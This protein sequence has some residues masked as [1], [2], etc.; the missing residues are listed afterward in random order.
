MWVLT[1]K[2]EQNRW[3]WAAGLAAAGI[4]TG[5][6]WLA[7]QELVPLAAAD[8]KPAA[9]GEKPA[10]DA[11]L[12]VVVE[13]D[14]A[15]VLAPA[16]RVLD[17]D[18]TEA[19]VAHFKK[20]LP[21]A[22]L[23]LSQRK[24]FHMVALGDS[25]VEMFGYDD[26]NQNWIKG[27]PARFA[28][29]LARQFFYTGGV[30]IVKPS[31][32]KPEKTQPHR[33]KEITLRNLGRG[34]KLSIHAM[35]PLSTYGL[36]TP[37]DLVLMSFG[38]NDSATGLDLGVY[39]KAFQDLIATV[40]AAGGE[41]VLLGPTTIVADPPEAD[42]A[43]TRPYSDTLR[44]VAEEAGAFYVDLGNL[45]SLV[46]VPEELD[47]PAEVFASVVDQ[48]RQFF[49][50]G[51]VVDW[52]H[53]R[54]ALHE[55]LGRLIF[56]ELVDGPAPVPWEVGKGELAILDAKTLELKVPVKNTTK[57]KAKYVVLPLVTPQWKPSDAKPEMELA[58]GESRELTIRYLLKDGVKVS[59]GMP[60][61]EPMLRL[62]VMVRSGE[63]V[64]IM[65]VRATLKPAVL[66]WKI[67]TQFNVEKE[68]HP[69][70]LLVNTSGAPLSG[71]WEATWMG[72][73]L[74]GDYRLDAGAQQELPLVF[75]LPGD[76][77]GQP[78][79]QSSDLTVVLTSGAQVL[80][81]TRRVDLT[82]N[83]GLKQPVSMMTSADKQSPM[84]PELGGRERSITLKAD[85]DKDTLFLTFDLR[86]ID[87]KDDPATGQS[88]VATLN[89]DAR[90]YGK[91]LNR[92]VT[93]PLR[94]NGPA[95]DG[96]ATVGAIP[97]WAFGTGYA[98]S[99]DEKHVK[100][101]VSSGSEGAR[102][103]TISL[104]RSYLY[105]HEWALGN[106]NSQI[107]INATF[108]FWQAPV[109]G[110]SAG[111]YLP[112]AQHSLLFNRH[113]DDAEGNAALELTTEPTQ[114]WT[115]TIQ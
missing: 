84:P 61:H 105:L 20:M 51:N 39:A 85:A 77:K 87:L 54:P 112:D 109:P 48:Y 5:A 41:V 1:P 49:D 46:K 4:L 91:R 53:P 99:F 106:G 17:F 68:Y 28:E 83:F 58:P 69:V 9:V 94:I 21:K 10:A 97:P 37:P 62:P 30:R 12:A 2:Y 52:V 42:M 45:T 102:R 14:E 75:K 43:K 71:T 115:L 32:G 113:R 74:T 107:G 67:E 55:K 63:T 26:D 6:G 66:L 88:W 11:K 78:F 64:R 76:F 111:G 56:Q 103:V 79:N 16:E 86:G 114:R 7:A 70:N 22:Y 25:I 92:G 93:D 65:D 13:E 38:I 35:Q 100:A 8:A 60:S 98:A 101:V 89:L 40:R 3:G 82:Q 59:A 34:G 81:F 31:K 33:G 95:S 18:L 108:T 50:H 72:Q 44:Q 104:P 57:A 73:K 15:A 27:Y 80:S 29:Q 24:P 90:S 110:G 23:K 19:Q 36:E 96:P 47:Q